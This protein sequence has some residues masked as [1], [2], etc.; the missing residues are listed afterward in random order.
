MMLFFSVFWSS[1]WSFNIYYCCNYFTTS[2][3]H[4]SYRTYHEKNSDSL[5]HPS[6]VTITLLNLKI[7]TNIY[8]HTSFLLI[9]ALRIIETC[10]GVTCCIIIKTTGTFYFFLLKRGQYKDCML[11]RV[12]S[13]CRIEVDKTLRRSENGA[14]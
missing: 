3:G 7:K 13:G 12:I 10:V 1:R 11:N 6:L 4:F 8:S 14:V 9:F 5:K 2:E